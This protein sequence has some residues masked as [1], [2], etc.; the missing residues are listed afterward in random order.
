MALLT[1]SD[2]PQAN[3]GARGNS[4]RQTRSGRVPVVAKGTK[5]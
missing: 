3:G 1:L 4:P 2:G 5:E